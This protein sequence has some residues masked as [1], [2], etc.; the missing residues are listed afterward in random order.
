VTYKI[1][2]KH[3]INLY[4]IIILKNMSILKWLKKNI[5]YLY[6][7]THYRRDNGDGRGE[8]TKERVH[9]ISLL[10]LNLYIGEA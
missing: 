9:T 2:I 4:S 6:N 7:I 1:I 5:K 8:H 3:V 10:N